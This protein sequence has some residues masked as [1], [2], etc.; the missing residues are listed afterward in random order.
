MHIWRKFQERIELCK[1]KDVCGAPD[2]TK[3]LFSPLVSSQDKL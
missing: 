2:Q 3:D 1:Q